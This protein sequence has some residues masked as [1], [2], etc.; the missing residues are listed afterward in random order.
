[1][2]DRLARGCGIVIPRAVAKGRATSYMSRRYMTGFELT[3]GSHE[4]P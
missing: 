4:K 1:M 3:I 2:L